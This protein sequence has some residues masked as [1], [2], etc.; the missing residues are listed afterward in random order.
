MQNLDKINNNKKFKSFETSK[1][2]RIINI[3]NKN[4]N[5]SRV[6]N[7]NILLSAR[8][9]IRLFNIKLKKKKISLLSN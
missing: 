2:N 3:T 6:N 8:N 1:S 9:Q 7:D 4:N 5:T